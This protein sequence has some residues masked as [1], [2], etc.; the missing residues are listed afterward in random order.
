MSKALNMVVYLWKISRQTIISQGINYSQYSEN[1]T[2]DSSRQALI[3]F[4]FTEFFNIDFLQNKFTKFHQIISIPLR[5]LRIYF[6]ENL[7]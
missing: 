6:D 4:S 3:N 1:N 2:G 5:Y 7:W